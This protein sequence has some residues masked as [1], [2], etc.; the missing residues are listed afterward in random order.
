LPKRQTIAQRVHDSWDRGQK[1]TKAAISRKH[2]VVEI[3]KFLTASWGV[4]A[5]APVPLDAAKWQ[6]AAMKG[7]RSPNA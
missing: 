6:P 3:D 4:V 2:F 7:R 1:Q 5:T